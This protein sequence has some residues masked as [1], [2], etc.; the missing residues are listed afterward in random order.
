MRA[1][2]RMGQQ[3]TP[4][5]VFLSLDCTA[6]VASPGHPGNSAGSP[7]GRAAKNEAL[8]EDWRQNTPDGQKWCAD[9]KRAHPDWDWSAIKGCT[10]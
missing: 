3:P 9:T 8:A 4:A 10:A 1:A 5:K 6:A 7:E 2:T